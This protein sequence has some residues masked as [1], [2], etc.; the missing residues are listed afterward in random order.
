MKLSPDVNVLWNLKKK[1]KKVHHA[2]KTASRGQFPGYRLILAL[3]QW[4]FLTVN[5]FVP[6][7]GKK[8]KVIGCYFFLQAKKAI[9]EMDVRK[10]NLECS[11]HC[12]NHKCARES[13]Q[14]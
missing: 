2:L 14:N 6:V 9:L 13:S 4:I 11:C 5:H 8:L 3:D 7:N 1:K 12:N 10:Y